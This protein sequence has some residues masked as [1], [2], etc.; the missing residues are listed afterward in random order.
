MTSSHRSALRRAAALTVVTLAT[1]AVT[2]AAAAAQT[3]VISGSVTYYGESTTL[4]LAGAHVTASNASGASYS[5]TTDANGNYEID[6]VAAPDDYSV[7][8]T[9][10]GY[11]GQTLT[12]IEVDDGSTNSVSV[13][14]QPQP[15]TVSGSVSD[16]DGALSYGVQIEAVPTGLGCPTGY[17]CGPEAVSDSGGHY[18]LSGLDP[19]SYDLFALDSGQTLSEG[20]IDVGPGSSNTIDIKLPPAPLPAGTTAKNA[21]R[22]L[23]YLNA[24]R[25]SLGLPAG[26]VLSSRW[27][28]DCAA[29]DAYERINRVLAHPEIPR[30]RARRLAAPGRASTRSSPSTCGKT[31]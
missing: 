31:A 10:P 22:D 14:L 18:L 26:I 30:A 28:T 17:V 2:A 29:H 15:G 6:N 11:D 16:S 5:A 19:G 4:P 3:G 8:F 23:G 13:T 1:F 24:L 20:T 25:R 7:T 9:A 12:G 21:Q 27:S